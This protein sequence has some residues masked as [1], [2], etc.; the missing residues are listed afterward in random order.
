MVK[1]RCVIVG[2]DAAGMSAAGQI[3]KRR[4]DADIVV[5][6]RS[7]Y[8]SYSACG[9]P[10]YIGGLVDSERRLVVRSPDEFR[11]RGNI[12]VRVRHDVLAI[13]IPK[14]SLRVRNLENGREHTDF[15]DKL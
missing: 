14:R 9:M 8:C 13:D 4:P 1:E 2:G 10:Y 3:R 5:Y 6:E 11:S 7:G 12:D 15:F